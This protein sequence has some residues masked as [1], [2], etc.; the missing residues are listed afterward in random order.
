MSRGHC[1]ADPLRARHLLSGARR[2]CRSKLHAVPAYALCGTNP[3]DAR[4]RAA[5]LTSMRRVSVT[6]L[7]RLVTA[8]VRPHARPALSARG[9]TLLAPPIARSRIPEATQAR[10]ADS[11]RRAAQGCTI[12]SPEAST[13]QRASNAPAARFILHA[14]QQTRVR[15]SRA[16]PERWPARAALPAVPCANQASIRVPA[17][18]QRVNPARAATTVQRVRHPHCPARLASSVVRPI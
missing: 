14:E 16:S 6:Q 8:P 15:V 1:H 13:L 11:G 5:M 9:P 3:P 10:T 18:Q 12:R 7:A 4:C 17:A 2:V